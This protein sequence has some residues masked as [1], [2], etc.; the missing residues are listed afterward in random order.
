MMAT[1]LTLLVTVHGAASLTLPAVFSDGCVLQTWDQG[2]ARS[3]VYGDAPPSAAVRVS[4]ISEDPALPFLRMYE[5][6]AMADGTWSVQEHLYG[7]LVP[8][9]P[10]RELWRRIHLRWRRVHAD[11]KQEPDLTCTLGHLTIHSCPRPLAV[12]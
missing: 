12:S 8:C 5:T 3:F 2:D 11:S 4:L 1:A 7:S 10:P 6:T 9:H